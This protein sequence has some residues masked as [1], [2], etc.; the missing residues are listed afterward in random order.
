[1]SVYWTVKSIPELKNI[2]ESERGKVWRAFFRTLSWKEWKYLCIFLIAGFGAVIGDHVLPFW[3]CLVG[4]TI[5]G[6]ISGQIAIE[7]LRPRLRE[8]LEKSNL[9]QGRQNA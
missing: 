5:G 1:M 6:F 9:P 7:Y 4:A 3:G 2:P 8:Y